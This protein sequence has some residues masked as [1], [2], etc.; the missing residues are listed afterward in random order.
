MTPNHWTMQSLGDLAYWV[1]SDFTAQIE[2]RLRF[3][4]SLHNA[5]LAGEERLKAVP[6]ALIFGPFLSKCGSREEEGQQAGDGGLAHVNL[7]GRVLFH[8]R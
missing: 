1:A 8:K 6:Y 2:T 4:R 7:R 3:P 5:R